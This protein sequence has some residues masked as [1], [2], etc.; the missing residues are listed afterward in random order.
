MIKQAWDYKSLVAEGS[1][2]SSG[3]GSDGAFTYKSRKVV[4][5][6]DANADAS[7]GLMSLLQTIRFLPIYCAALDSG[8]SVNKYY[9]IAANSNLNY[10]TLMYIEECEINCKI[11]IDDYELNCNGSLIDFLKQIFMI[12]NPETSI[13][14]EEII[15]TLSSSGLSQIPYEEYINVD[16]LDEV[17]CLTLKN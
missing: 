4:W 1:S 7:D 11:K 2:N 6:V 12:T 5:K 17:G 14:D 8:R 13:T 9:G 10:A 3:G 16:V 15:Q